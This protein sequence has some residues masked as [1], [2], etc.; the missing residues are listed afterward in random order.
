MTSIQSPDIYNVNK[1]ENKVLT[2]IKTH[3]VIEV[4]QFSIVKTIESFHF[5][6]RANKQL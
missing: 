3:L 6:K 5:E 2:E 1:K 4:Q